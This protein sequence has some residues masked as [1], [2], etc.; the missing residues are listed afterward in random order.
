MGL[1]SGS[2]R[3]L[4]S[5]AT[6][7]AAAA[8]LRLS[9]KRRAR[10]GHVP[11][12]DP[13]S[14]WGPPRPGTLPRPGPYSKGPRAHPR[15]PACLLG[16]SGL[17][18]TGVRCPSVEVRTQWCILD[19]LSFLATWCLHTIEKGTPDSGYRQWHIAPGVHPLQHLWWCNKSPS[20]IVIHQG[21]FID[22]I[23][24]YSL[25]FWH[26]G[27]ILPVTPKPY[28]FPPSGL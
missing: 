24:R 16:S 21:F 11:A 10:P 17:I 26:N 20:K 14:R 22:Q 19:V 18:H 5:W 27:D 1:T 3:W 23:Y 7:H 25:S 6:S 13:C 2:A 4:M 15:D 8:S 12:P 9:G 28:R